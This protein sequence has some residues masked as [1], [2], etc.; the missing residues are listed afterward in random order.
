MVNL[1]GAIA[2]TSLITLCWHTYEGMAWPTQDFVTHSQQWLI[3]KVR[4][5][6]PFKSCRSN[7]TYQSIKSGY[8]RSCWFKP[9]WWKLQFHHQI[10]S[11]GRVPG[12]NDGL[13]VYWVLFVFKDQGFDC[14][15]EPVVKMLW[16][17]VLLLVVCWRGLLERGGGL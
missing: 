15:C 10:S 8:F 1:Y 4:V 13:F 17:G 7:R 5:I 9:V 12:K 16:C 2:F 11:T 14:S 6:P 3:I